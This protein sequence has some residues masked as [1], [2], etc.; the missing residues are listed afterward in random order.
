MPAKGAAASPLTKV[1]RPSGPW[2]QERR[3]EFVDFR[4]QWDGRLNR[5]D[6]IEHFGI[7]VPQ[8]SLDIAKYIELAPKNLVYD[9]SERLYVAAADFRP[10]YSSSSAARFLSDL[11]ARESGY[12]ASEASY[13]GWAPPVAVAGTPARTV[14]ADVLVAV[15]RA[16]RARQ[17]MHVLY[18]S[19]SRPE[20]TWREVSPHALGHDGFRWHLRAFCHARKAFRDF[21]FARVLEVKPGRDSDV[22]AASDVAWSTMLPLILIPNPKLSASKR[23]VVELDYAMVDGRVTLQVRQAMLYY[24]LQR[25]GLSRDGELRPEAQQIALE[26]STEVQQVLEGLAKNYD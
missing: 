8:A 16:I 20:P 12:L 4:L 14:T 15:V 17:T 13:V 10:V 2:G 25:L 18:Q 26:N 11:L 24:S 22:D 23:R 1:K 6:L 5:V 9:R 3:L 21:V 19:M 7:S